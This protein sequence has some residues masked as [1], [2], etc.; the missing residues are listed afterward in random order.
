[1]IK[2][3]QLNFIKSNKTYINYLIAI[4]MMIFAFK[5]PSSFFEEN[6]KIEYLEVLAL[7]IG[8][9]FSFLEYFKRRRFS[10]FFLTCGLILVLFIGRELSW[11]RVFF[12]TDTGNIVRSKDWIYRIHSHFSLALYIAFMLIH[13]YKTKFMQTTIILIKN[14]PIMVYDFLL[15]ILLAVLSTAFESYYLEI[16]PK[17]IHSFHIAL[18]ESA[19]VAMYFAISIII[20]AYSKENILE[21]INKK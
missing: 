8:A 3:M 13:A 15:I 5:A 12:T 16:L 9:I 21:K 19:E 1:M 6:G 14:A 10:N 20:Y 7:S 11:G 2:N 17:S 4:I 18:E